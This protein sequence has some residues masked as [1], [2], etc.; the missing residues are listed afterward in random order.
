VDLTINSIESLRVIWS[1]VAR[2][3]YCQQPIITNWNEQYRRRF[4]PRISQSIIY[5]NSHIWRSILHTTH[6]ELA[7][8][9]YSRRG[10]ASYLVSV[11]LFW[12]LVVTDCQFVRT[13]SEPGSINYAEQQLDSWRSQFEHGQETSGFAILF[14]LSSAM[15]LQDVKSRS[16]PLHP[17]YTECIKM[18]GAV[19]ICHY[20]Y[21]NA[22]RSK[23]PTWNETAGVQVFWACAIPL[24][25]SLSVCDV[26]K[27]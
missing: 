26:T 18:I 23:F 27:R 24:P 22:R 10:K 20:G 1:R 2:V 12:V 11:L 7:Q 8:Y 14:S 13:F 19:S 21:Q 3:A 15:S 4:L 5:N 16:L 9:G 17:H 25:S 6:V